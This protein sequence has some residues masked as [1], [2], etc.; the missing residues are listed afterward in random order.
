MSKGSIS[1]EENPTP[2]KGIRKENKVGLIEHTKHFT[3]P[4]FIL[5]RHYLIWQNVIESRIVIFLMRNM[6]FA[7]RWKFKSW[8]SVLWNCVLM[9][10]DYQRFRGSYCLHFQEA[11]WPSETLV[12]YRITIR[13]RN[14]EDPNLTP[15]LIAPLILLTRL[16]HCPSLA[17]T[18]N[19]RASLSYWR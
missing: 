2:E 15:I 1:K 4:V 13:C 19:V 3:V 12:S 6:R 7:P 11:A 17:S 5:H 8:C 18:V 10:K 14:P 9:I 16:A